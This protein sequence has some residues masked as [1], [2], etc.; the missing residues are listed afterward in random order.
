M[1]QSYLKN[2]EVAMTKEQYFEMCELMETEPIESEIP[3]EQDDFPEAVQQA[4]QIYYLLRDVWEGMSGTYMGKD[5]S[6]IFDF[7]RLY[8]VDSR[9]Q[10]LTLGF[11]RQIDS[12]RSEIFAEKQKAR[13]ASRPKA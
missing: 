10:L 4:F 12:V 2:S 13:E 5:F 11:I 3:I 1:I 9:D 6:T 7:F 8:E